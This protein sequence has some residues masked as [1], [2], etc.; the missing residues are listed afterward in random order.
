[1]LRNLEYRL[2][3]LRE[4]FSKILEKVT[5]E[6]REQIM[7]EKELNLENL[8]KLES[9]LEGA[10]E[11]VNT[12]QD[13]VPPHSKTTLSDDEKMLIA[14][15]DFFAFFKEFK[16]ESFSLILSQ[17]LTLQLSSLR[18]EL[19]EFT[20]RHLRRLTDP[21]KCFPTQLYRFFLNAID[22][23]ILDE[24]KAHGSALT[25]SS[26]FPSEVLLRGGNENLNLQL[27]INN[28]TP[29]LEIVDEKHIIIG[30]RKSF[31]IV[32]FFW[33]EIDRDEQVV[34]HKSSFFKDSF[35]KSHTIEE[36]L[37]FR[38]VVSST[39]IE[40]SLK[41]DEEP[42]SMHCI[43]VFET[44]ANNKKFLILGGNHN[45]GLFIM[46]DTLQSKNSL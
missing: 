43:C 5:G 3:M 18:R 22:A 32:R 24:D 6:F 19:D 41:S 12:Q 21:P 28:R 29:I 20:G 9:I 2:E 30:T 36:K 44:K 4:H 8:E 39:S 10:L 38:K 42:L 14:F 34:K 31:E 13:K 26:I 25:M 37:K 7:N 11:S 45:V 1:M 17:P 15:Q 40:E 16:E 27:P 46:I 23:N 33:D 35:I